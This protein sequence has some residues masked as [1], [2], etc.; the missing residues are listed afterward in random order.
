M[1]RRVA[2]QRLQE[3][4]PVAP[5][6]Q[7]PPR[8]RGLENAFIAGFLALQIAMPLSYYLGGRGYDERFSWRMFSTLR[9]RDCTVRVLEQSR[10]GAPPQPV[11][12][13]QDVQAS[14][15]RLLERQRTAVI[16]KYLA[17]RCRRGDVWQVEYVRTCQDTDGR[18]LPPIT[19]Q[20]RCQ[21][22]SP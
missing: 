20:L 22:D 18:A 5:P 6:Q 21:E 12:L 19:Q 15:V 3:R 7:Q 13:E 8:A 14:W 9:L 16:D 1:T 4:K 11:A 17:R 2:Q 10:E